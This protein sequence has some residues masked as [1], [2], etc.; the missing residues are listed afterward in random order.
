MYNHSRSVRCGYFASCLSVAL[1]CL[2]SS[3]VQAASQPLLWQVQ[4]K[5]SQ[6]RLYLFGSLHYGNEAFYPLPDAVLQAYR[7]A[8]VLAVE[9]D[10]DALD[11]Q[12][13][14]T[15]LEQHGYYAGEK[16]LQADLDTQTWTSLINVANSL[17]IDARQLNQ[18]KPWLMAMQLTNRQLALSD[19]Q[20]SL[21][22]D[23]YFLSVAHNKKAVLELESL[24]EQMQLFN[25]LSDAEQIAFL[26]TTLSDHNMAEESLNKLA[27]AWYRGDEQALHTLVFSAFHKR[28]LGQ[29]LYQSIFVERNKK[30]LNVI[31]AQLKESQ[32]IF[33]VVGVGHMLGKDGLVSLF[34]ERG[35]RVT[36]VNT[37]QK[38]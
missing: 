9:L 24:D 38:D 21:G 17:N 22:L 30:M 12:K 27:D 1:I 31:D 7:E 8:D 36:Q 35:Y 37:A 32:K 13:V 20:Q 6:V 18:F 34:E 23:K 25:Q 15:A 28:E 3:I 29:K 11:G 14:R 10:I 2:Y 19:Y 33:L 16:N 26:Q 4:D 5:E